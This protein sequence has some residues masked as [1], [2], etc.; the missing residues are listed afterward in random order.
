MAQRIAIGSIYLPSNGGYTIKMN[1]RCKVKS[2]RDSVRSVVMLVLLDWVDVSSCCLVKS[3]R[4]FSILNVHLLCRSITTRVKQ[5]QQ[6][7]LKPSAHF[8]FRVRMS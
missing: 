2:W 7:S 6:V 3:S 1:Y 4:K 5:V 8:L